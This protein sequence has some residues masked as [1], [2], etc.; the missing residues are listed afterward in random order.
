VIDAVVNGWCVRALVD[1]GCSKSI[2]ASKLSGVCQGACTVIAVD[3]SRV[4]CRGETVVP[5]AVG[6]AILRVN[7]VVAEKLLPGVDAI[8][9][10]D[11]I[12]LLG[13]V[14]VSA[15]KV[16]FVRDERGTAAGVM[17]VA[18]TPV[19][20]GVRTA[21]KRGKVKCTLVEPNVEHVEVERAAVKC[22]VEHSEVERAAAKCAVEH[23]KVEPVAVKCVVEHAEVERAVVERAAV[24][25]TAGERAAVERTVAMRAEVERAEFAVPCA[26]GASTPRAAGSGCA[27]VTHASVERVDGLCGIN[28]VEVSADQSV[29][30]SYER[31]T[32]AGVTCVAATPSGVGV[33]VERAEVERVA[34]ECAVDRAE[35]ERVAVEYAVDRAEVERVAVECAV[36]RAEVDRA[37]VERVAVECAVD[38]AEVDRAE[39]ERVAVECAVDRAVVKRAEVKPTWSRNQAYVGSGCAGP[40]VTHA[41]VKRANA[42]VPCDVGASVASA[43]ADAPPMTIDDRDFTAQFDGTSWVV[44]WRWIDGPPDLRNT[45]ACY[46]STIKP[47]TQEEF[48]A[49]VGRWITNGWLKPSPASSNGVIPLMAVVQHNKHKVRPVLDFREL[50]EFVTCHTGSEVAVCDETLRKWR[51]FPGSLK[52]VDLKS[53]YLQ[54]HIDKS[55][56]PFQQVRYKGQTYCLTRLGFGLNCAPRIMTRIL[57]EV[58]AASERIRCA[59]DHYIDDII[60]MED[61]VP[62]EEVVAHLKRYGLESKPPESLEG[63]RVLGLQ[64]NRTK[65]GSLSFG[66]GNEIPVVA[67][68]AVVTKKQLFSICGKLVGHYPVCGWLR[69]ACSFL[70]RTC[71]GA[72]WKDAAGE[73]A[74]A[75]L[76]ELLVRVRADDP[77]RGRWH[78]PETNACRVW[79]DAS[80]LAFGAVLEVQGETVEDAAWLRKTSDFAH[81]NVAELEAVL[82]GLNLALKWKMTTVEIVTDSATVLGWLRC[83]VTEDHRIKTHGAAEMLIKRRLAVFKEL[84]SEFGLTVTVTLTR[85]ESNRADALTRVKRTWLNSIRASPPE[86]T[87]A[88]SVG[89][90]HAQHHFGVDRSLY[91]ARLTDPNTA[92][93]DVEECIR[94]CAQCQSIDPAPIQHE[95]G[96]LS[97]YS[98]WTRIAIDTTHY[99][100]RCYLSIIDC[101]P[102]RFAIW[103]EVVSENAA[104]VVQ[105]LDEVFRE[106]GPPEELLMDNSTSFHSYP[107]ATLC[108]K[109]NVRR[110]FRAAYRP[111]GNGIVERHHRTVKRMA[112][113]VG[114]HSPLEMVFWY[115]MAPK[116]GVDV[117]T[118]PCSQVFTYEWRHPTL[119]P[120]HKEAENAVFKVGDRVWVKPPNVR[121]TT[122]WTIGVVTK[123]TSSNNVEV[124]GMPRHVLDLRQ[125]I[126]N[127]EAANVNV[128]NAQPFQ[129]PRHTPGRGGEE[130]VNVLAPEEHYP[131]VVEV[132]GAVIA[133]PEVPGRYPERVR[134]T[135]EWYDGAERSL[136]GCSVYEQ[137]L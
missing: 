110:R 95:R 115:N 3:G 57:R 126:G 77:V 136:V 25:R 80:C 70:K 120:L 81:I 38:R 102:S 117:S 94:A 36:D 137:D 20:V 37:E 55:L 116:T 54:I 79:C 84:V 31:G 15:D 1:T 13:G 133:M 101:G 135:P 65:S 64:M 8:L 4:R 5:I 88:V 107:V 63:G 83:T 66:R 68:N 108:E 132:E 122:R 18:A 90:S 51:R 22:A 125:V 41:S 69:V 76:L 131:P 29:S 134:A 16:V 71:I 10:M 67:E 86:T 87:C 17:C 114:A 49:E 82:K 43:D 106:R 129:W 2:V 91:L 7:C 113:R 27:D 6:G 30:V 34:V 40:D 73:Q 112:A 14:E 12:T 28:G 24:E 119:R 62:A 97:V 50:N 46:S 111:S 75:M 42:A 23:T 128:E 127:E 19:G 61:A 33:R 98:N 56:W 103:R 85:S 35:V 9:G 123:V 45:V 44:L 124:D 58:L 60:V 100:G 93:R 39:V 121:C 21:V 11:I 89:A 105:T 130:D 118:V 96:E 92:R 109:W 72:S 104:S 52:L 78:V 48:D 99:H 53:A 59:T 47:E 74:Q 26:V 32:A